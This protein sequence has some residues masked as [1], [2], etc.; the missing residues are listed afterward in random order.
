MSDTSLQVTQELCHHLGQFKGS[1][2]EGPQLGVDRR[3][4]YDPELILFVFPSSN[5]PRESSN[6]PGLRDGTTLVKKI[7]TGNY[8]SA[9]G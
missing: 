4:G 7:V 9:V 6:I 2:I 1:Q 8:N 3:L 5:D